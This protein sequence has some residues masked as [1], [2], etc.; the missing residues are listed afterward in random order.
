MLGAGNLRCVGA[1]GEVQRGGEVEVGE[2]C[3][4]E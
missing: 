3:E 1:E 4:E 2:R